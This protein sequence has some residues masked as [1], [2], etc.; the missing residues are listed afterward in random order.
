MIKV[1][2]PNG[3][4]VEG[5]SAIEVTNVIDLLHTDPADER[6]PADVIAL[7]VREPE[8]PA[9]PQPKVSPTYPHRVSDAKCGLK[10]GAREEQ[11]LR[12][13]KMIAEIN[14]SRTTELKSSEISELTEVPVGNVSSALNGLRAKGLVQHGSHRQVWVITRK[15]WD[16]KY[17]VT[18]PIR[19]GK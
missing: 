12:A 9:E 8:V 16:T 18:Y 11:V 3:I 2:L 15:G 7:P 6:E 19:A 5:D 4:T 14:E 1:T 13:G 10:I 17:W